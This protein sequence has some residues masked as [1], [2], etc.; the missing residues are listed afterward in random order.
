MKN[1]S[2][3]NTSAQHGGAV[4]APPRLPRGNQVYASV[5]LILASAAA[6]MVASAQDSDSAATELAEVSVTGTRIVRDGYQAPTPLTVVGAEEIQT[7]G[8]PNVADYVNTIP[9]F[10]GSR[11]P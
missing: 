1:E 7:S 9:S 2:V 6:S 4:A 10:A 5:V 11:M 3:A 8:S